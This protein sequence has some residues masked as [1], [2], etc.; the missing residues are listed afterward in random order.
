MQLLKIK[1]FFY[2]GYN[3]IPSRAYLH[4]TSVSMRSYIHTKSEHAI[5]SIGTHNKLVLK[6]NQYESENILSKLSIYI[7]NE[8]KKNVLL[9]SLI[10]IFKCLSILFLF[11]RI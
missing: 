5:Y 1:N 10:T 2:H 9:L 3:F 7:Y 11:S 8:L 6:P 4:V